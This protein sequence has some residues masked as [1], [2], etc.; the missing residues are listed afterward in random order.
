MSVDDNSKWAPW[1]HYVLPLAVIHALAQFAL[2]RTTS[3][4]VNA[5][6]SIV[7]TVV[8]FA[9]VT[10]WWRSRTRDHAEVRR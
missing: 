6:A 5:I 10:V 9:A 3:D 4:V 2:L 8:V 7:I 1:Y